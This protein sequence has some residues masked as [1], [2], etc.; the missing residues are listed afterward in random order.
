MLSQRVFLK[1]SFLS[2]VGGAFLSTCP[3][4]QHHTADTSVRALAMDGG[5]LCSAR[6]AEQPFDVQFHPNSQ[7]FVAG[8]ITGE[9]RPGVPSRASNQSARIAGRIKPCRQSFALCPFL[10]HRLTILTD[11]PRTRPRTSS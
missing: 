3:R 1:K 7:V 4:F 9:V 5:E 11:R 6:C 2:A 10:F 8:L